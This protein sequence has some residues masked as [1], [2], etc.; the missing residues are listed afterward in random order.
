LQISEVVERRA[1]GWR[2]RIEEKGA[3]HETAGGLRRDL[4]RSGRHFVWPKHTIFVPGEQCKNRD[5]L[6]VMGMGRPRPVLLGY[7]VRAPQPQITVCFSSSL[8]V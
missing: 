7:R 2:Q 3:P 1:D 4:K 5:L 8:G 6:R